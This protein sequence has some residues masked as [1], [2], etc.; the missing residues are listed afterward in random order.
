VPAAIAQGLQLAR[1]GGSYLVVGQYTDSGDTA[2]NPHQIVHRRLNIVGSWAF[3]GA[4]L[5]KYVQL[6]PAMLERF[7]LARLVTSYGM[8]DHAAALAGV[9]SGTVMKA[10][11]VSSSGDVA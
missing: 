9:A 5:V 6:L 1:R 11:L 2:I 3:T 8:A 10:V 4:H 7:D